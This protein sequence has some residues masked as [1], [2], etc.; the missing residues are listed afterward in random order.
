MSFQQYLNAID[1]ARLA[2]DNN[3]TDFAE[4]LAARPA[5]S[6][7]TAAGDNPTALLTATLL[8]DLQQAAF[9][10]AAINGSGVQM[11]PAKIIQISDEKKQ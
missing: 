10:V 4:V 2:I 8:D 3:A 5:S 9:D 6:I 7:D 1:T 11:K